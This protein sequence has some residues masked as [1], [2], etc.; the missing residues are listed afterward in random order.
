MT[1]T[2]KI[3]HAIVDFADL[4]SKPSSATR[5]GAKRQACAAIE[6]SVPSTIPKYVIIDLDFDGAEQAQAFLQNL[7][8]VW[9]RVDQSPGLARP[10]GAAATRPQ[11]RIV[12]EVDSR[13]Y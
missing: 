1:T 2:L 4:E 11:T 13:K 5:S 9:S 7:E 12:Q 10:P 3:E 6:S 8:S